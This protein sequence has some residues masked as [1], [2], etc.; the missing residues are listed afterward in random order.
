MFENPAGRLVRNQGEAEAYLFRFISENRQAT[1]KRMIGKSH[2]FDL[3][4]PW[5][6][7]ILDNIH[8]QE[9]ETFPMRDLQ[10]LY[11]DAAWNLVMQGFLRPGPRKINGDSPSSSYGQG[12]TLTALGEKRLNEEAVTTADPR[13]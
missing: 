13:D 12:Y 1:D 9:G 7:E 11:M 5:L 3:Y 2:D 4:L 8:E 10:R 6:V